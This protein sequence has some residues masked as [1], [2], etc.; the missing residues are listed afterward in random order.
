MKSDDSYQSQDKK[1]LQKKGLGEWMS[2][3]HRFQYMK[4]IMHISIIDYLQEWNL[5]KK[6]E[7][8]WKTLIQR[9]DPQ[10]ISAIEPDAYAQRFRS[11]M[12]SY[13]FNN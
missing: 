2:Q 1:S 10:R 3:Q 12:E 5:S 11:F 7:R 6:S 8:A 13:V 9:K 4:K